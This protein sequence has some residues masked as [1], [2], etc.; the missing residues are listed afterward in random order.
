MATPNMYEVLKSLLVERQKKNPDSSLRSLA[1]DLSISPSRLSLLL[2][3]KID[4]TRELLDKIKSGNKLDG[5]EKRMLEECYNNYYS[6]LD[7][8][9]TRSLTLEESIRVSGWEFGA[10]RV[11]LDSDLGPTD[12]ESISKHFGISVEKVNEVIQTM[13]DLELLEKKDGKYVLHA[14]SI[15]KDVKPSHDILKKSL[16]ELCVRGLEC[17]EWA[18]PEHREFYGSTF[19]I[20]MELVPKIKKLISKCINDVGECTMHHKKG[21]VYRLN[22]QFFP[23]RDGKNAPLENE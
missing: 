3:G 12:C 16:G 1:K 13:I 4:L 11:Y 14:K 19:S 9:P 18:L 23:M 21:E 8:Q 5:E 15:S 17:I 6:R 7:V 2:N 20:P 22:I 10:I